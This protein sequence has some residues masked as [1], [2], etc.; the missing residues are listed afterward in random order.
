MSWKDILDQRKLNP[1]TSKQVSAEIDENLLTD[2]QVSA[3]KRS[4]RMLNPTLFWESMS[5]KGK[6]IEGLD[7]LISWLAN[8]RVE[9][10][11]KMKKI[12]IFRK[13]AFYALYYFIQTLDAKL[14]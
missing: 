5:E 3:K 9:N 12:P 2:K 8:K 11:R 4:K 13:G 10:L 7:L 6:E 1:L 14:E